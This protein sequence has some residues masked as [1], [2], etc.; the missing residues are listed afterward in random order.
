MDA[1]MRLC[2]IRILLCIWR[3]SHC[4]G[5]YLSDR[6]LFWMAC[7]GKLSYQHNLACIIIVA[8]TNSYHIAGST[9]CGTIHRSAVF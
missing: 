5:Y 6:T 7:S 4:M 1:L 8:V 3:V 2:R 9:H